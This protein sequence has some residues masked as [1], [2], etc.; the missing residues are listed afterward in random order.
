MTQVTR[1]GMVLPLLLGIVVDIEDP[2]TF[3]TSVH[4][5]MHLDLQ[6]WILWD[7]WLTLLVIEYKNNLQEKIKNRRDLLEYK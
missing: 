5:I 1:N 3:P 7:N 4:L 6:V 2:K